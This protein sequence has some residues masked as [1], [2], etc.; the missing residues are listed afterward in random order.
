MTQTHLAPSARSWNRMD[1]IDVLRGL[2][3][4]FVLMNHV[5]MRLLFAKVP[6]SQGLPDQL[7]SSLV[8]N[9]QLG[10]QMFFVISGYLITL[11]SIRRWRG[12]EAL[13]IK[14]FYL[15]RLARI[16]PLMILLLLILS[17]L[18]LAHV[19]G[20]IV[21]PKTGGLGRALLAALM[22]HVGYLE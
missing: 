4:L 18:H 20:Y 3:I 9:G 14:S 12:L 13:E 1:G 22:F 19:P 8:W 2:S 16:A 5:N 10:V 21:S 17:G 11:T 7:V 6:Y 15:L